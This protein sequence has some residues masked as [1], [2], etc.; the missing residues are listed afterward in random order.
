MNAI[1][2]LKDYAVADGWVKDKS[3]SDVT[4][5][6]IY[7]ML[8]EMPDVAELDRDRRRHW[9]DVQK[10]SRVGEHLISWWACEATGDRGADEV[11]WEFDPSLVYFAEQKERVTIETYYDLCK[12]KELK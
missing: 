4:D 9:T 5:Q 6:D 7:W 10:V 12:S 1:E 8:C 2:Y 3:V 11:G